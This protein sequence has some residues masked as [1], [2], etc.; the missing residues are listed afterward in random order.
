MSF[1][2]AARVFTLLTVGDGLVAQ[3]PAL[4]IS[5]AAGVIATR[6]NDG[7]AL[8]GQITSEFK[9]H[10]KA[11]YISGAALGLFALIPG[12][13]GT[14]FLLMGF[15]IGFVGYRIEKSAEQKIID[16][17][18]AGKLK[19]I[20]DV[21]DSTGVQGSEIE[22]EVKRGTNVDLLMAKLF[23]TTNLE[24]SFGCNFNVLVE[25]KPQTL[26]TDDILKEWLIFRVET[27]K[28]I[29]SYDLKRKVSTYIN[30]KG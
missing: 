10:P 9:I 25:N 16:D 29:L 15:G 28:R 8:G 20:N 1:S 27:V 24:S 18:K 14:P 17:A 6:N 2:D 21:N 19:E 22:I 5:T 26:G 7:N 11:F 23:K 30:L 4:V 3:I 13:P 12:F